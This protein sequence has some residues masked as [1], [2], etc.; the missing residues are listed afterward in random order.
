MPPA[1]V[2]ASPRLPQPPISLP[3][4]ALP[5]PTGPK[6]RL[7]AITTAYYKYS[8]A[9]DLITKLIEGYG[10]VGRV[11]LP[12]CQVERLYVEQFPDSDIGRGM[13]A[14]YEIPL[15]A[16]VADALCGD[17]GTLAVDGVV[18]VGE[19]GD[20]PINE[21]GQKLYPRRRLFGEIVDVF[22]RAGRAVPVFNDKHL[23][24][25][26]DDAL[27][28]YRQ[29]QRLGFPLMAG[30]SVPVA[31]RTP[32]L[33]FANGVSLDAALSLYYLPEIPDAVDYASYHALE[34]L[35]CFVEHRA[36]SGQG[37]RGVEVFC[38]S[39]AWHAAEAGLWRPE[40]ALAAAAAVPD[41]RLPRLSEADAAHPA[42]VRDRLRERDPDPVVVRVE[43]RDG[44]AAAAYLTRTL[45]H[46]EFCFAAQLAG[47]PRP[48]ATWFQMLKPQRDH[49]SFL[50]NHMEVMF[51]SGQPS[52]PV[53]RTLLVTGILAAAADARFAGQHVPTPHLENLDYQPWEE[54]RGN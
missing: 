20:F 37:V 32:P 44:F 1:D 54:P 2:F 19:H 8:H 17:T 3:T 49:F 38:G 6:L 29:A 18:L 4:D 21:K 9:D 30:S 10:V 46:D 23:A 35:Q 12:H 53:E 7:A 41:N 26:W 24:Y 40:L 13:A 25:D 27:W 39:D 15:V 47:Q 16:T 42:V 43:Y 36:N 31:W 5:P 48:L 11:H 45:V 33:G 22:E 51:R 14:R 34:T 52:Y 50:A 28:M